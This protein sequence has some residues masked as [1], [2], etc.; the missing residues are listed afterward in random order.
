MRRE[1]L[2]QVVA[3]GVGVAVLLRILAA[4]VG[5]ALSSPVRWAEIA[6]G[7]RGAEP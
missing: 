7:P 2:P 1:H 4:P 3:A 5:R 6:R